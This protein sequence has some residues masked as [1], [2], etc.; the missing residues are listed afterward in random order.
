MTKV[1]L[2]LSHAVTAVVAVGVT[3]AAYHYAYNR[4][5]QAAL[6]RF[7]LGMPD[8]CE[9]ATDVAYAYASAGDTEKY[10]HWHSRASGFCSYR[11][12]AFGY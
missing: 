9:A 3:V 10:R 1:H 5:L 4:E 12:A 6:N 2:I 11:K 8:K 7:E